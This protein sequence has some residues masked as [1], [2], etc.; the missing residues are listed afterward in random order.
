MRQNQ[1]PFFTPVIYLSKQLDTTTQGWPACLC[2]L[3]ATALL[4]QESKKIS[5]EPPVT[6]GFK[7][8]LSHKSMTLL[9]ASHVPLIHVILLESPHF[10]FEH[11]PTLNLATLIPNSSVHPIHTCKEAKKKNAHISHI[12]STP[13]NNPDFTWYMMAAYLQNHKEKCTWICN[14]L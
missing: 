14:C 12:S 1:E 5:F 6:H 9:S 10:S 3:A 2:A 8:L 13:L 7:D 11:C 4:A